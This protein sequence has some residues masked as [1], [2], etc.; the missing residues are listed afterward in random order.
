MAEAQSWVSNTI[1]RAST[2][3]SCDE[4]AATR[5]VVLVQ[6][7]PLFSNIPPR[8]CREIIS[9]ARK[10]VYKRRETIHLAGDPVRQMVLLMSGCVK[11]VQ[12]GQNGS[13]VI[14]R[15]NGPGEAFGMG[16]PNGQ[17]RHAS[18]AQT[19]SASTALVW[20]IGVFE[21]LAERFPVLRRNTTHILSKRLEELEE[22]FREVSTEKVATRLS[23]QIVRL[24]GQVGRQVNGEVQINLSREELAQLIGT[25]L[26]TVS[27]LLSDWDEQGIVSAQRESVTVKNLEA[28]VELSERD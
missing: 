7:L 12:I 27:R 13:E 28:L 1:A 21:S 2:N 26:F 9:S 20:E 19:V 4:N 16:G 15:L 22:R 25:T 10:E 18:S 24:L 6:H 17:T 11:I 23:N 8:E 5:A 3:N 14:L